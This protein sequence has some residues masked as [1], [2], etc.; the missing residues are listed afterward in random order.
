MTDLGLN[1]DYTVGHGVLFER[2]FTSLNA[3][4]NQCV[5][6]SI[7]DAAAHFW[8]N[9]YDAARTYLL[10]VAIERE[11]SVAAQYDVEFFVLFVVVE[12]WQCLTS[13]ERAE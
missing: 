12:K 2:V 5:V 4:V 8:R 1:F 10:V 3:D 7:L 6:A 13:G 11:Y 9:L